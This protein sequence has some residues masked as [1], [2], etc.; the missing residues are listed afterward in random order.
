MFGDSTSG[1]I[2][3]NLGDNLFELR[4]YCT[5]NNLLFQLRV[6]KR[7][8]APTIHIVYRLWHDHEYMQMLDVRYV[9]PKM[10]KTSA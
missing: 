4:K 3:Y 1:R 5:E 2:K 10:L 7:N 6:N 8:G 9:D